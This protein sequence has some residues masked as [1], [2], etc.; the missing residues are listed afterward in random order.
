M[1]EIITHFLLSK[2]TLWGSLGMFIVFI[3]SLFESTPFLGLI[4]PAQTILV[5]SGFFTHTSNFGFWE[6]FIIAVIGSVI[7]DILS[8]YIGRR[9]GTTLLSQKGFRFLIKKEY[10]EKT[11]ALVDEHLGKTLFIGRMSSITRSLAPFIAGSSKARFGRFL[12]W[13]TFGALL[14]SFVFIGIGF[15]FAESFRILGPSIGK[16]ILSAVSIIVILFTLVFFLR[17]K[18]FYIKNYHAS[19][20]VIFS[21]ALFSLSVLGQSV[22]EKTGIKE[23]DVIINQEL[24]TLRTPLQTQIMLPLTDIADKVSLISV[25]ILIT[26]LFFLR[27]KYKD[28]LL[29]LW[30]MALGALS[31]YVLK[32]LINNPRPV[33][34]II[35]ETGKSFP[36]GHATLAT[37]FALTLGFI[38]LKYVSSEAK[39]VAIIVG[40]VLFPLS[41]AYSRLYLGVHWLSDVLAGFLLGI[42]TVSLSLLIF[43]FVP[44]LYKKIKTR[45]IVI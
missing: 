45:Q 17:K 5:L 33:L 14:W 31:V 11:Q 27:K 1:E 22:I 25:T 12:V 40:S 44:W 32:V 28:G 42:C 24:M 29:L 19:A 9:F 43:D 38:S 6:V 35:E 21:V 13:A 41:I 18:H 16:F 37:V 26:F 23:A 8:F 10:I 34:S 7:G 36:S 20:I 4:I 39:K 30:S 3:S 15:V 2:S